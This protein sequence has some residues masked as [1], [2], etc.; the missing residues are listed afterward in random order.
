M[1]LMINKKSF[2]VD[3]TESALSVIEIAV[4][5]LVD[6]VILLAVEIISVCFAIRICMAGMYSVINTITIFTSITKSII[7]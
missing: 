1:Q 2:A 5:F 6:L 3:V 4:N 7:D